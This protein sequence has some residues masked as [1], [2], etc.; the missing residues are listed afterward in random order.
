MPLIYYCEI[1]LPKEKH[2]AWHFWEFSYEVIALLR[3]LGR[4]H[5]GK[6]ALSSIVGDSWLVCQD[7]FTPVLVLKGHIVQEGVD[8]L[9]SPYMESPVRFA[10]SEFIIGFVFP[11]LFTLSCHQL[12]SQHTDFTANML[13]GDITIMKI[14]LFSDITLRIVSGPHFVCSWD[15]WFLLGWAVLKL[16]LWGLEN[17]NQVETRDSFDSGTVLTGDLECWQVSFLV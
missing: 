5:L 17:I 13:L 9:W 8:S 7:G 11:K 12:D 6:V 3:M 16:F 14:E 15:N 1:W 2:W 4:G 10:D